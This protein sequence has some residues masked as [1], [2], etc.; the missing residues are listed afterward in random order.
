MHPLA[1]TGASAVTAG[2]LIGFVLGFAIVHSEL[3]WEKTF[4]DFFMLKNGKIGSII[5]FSICV[6]TFLFFLLKLA[7]AVQLHIKPSSFWASFIG[8]A[9]FGAGVF[10]CRQV[11]ITSFALFGTGRTYALWTLAGMLLAIPAVKFCSGFLSDT[12]YAFSPPFNYEKT[13][14]VYMPGAL[15]VGII[16]FIALLLSALF[17]FMFSGASDSGGGDGKK[18]SSSGKSAKKPKGKKGK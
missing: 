13:I 9:I 5:L 18:S 7:G 1:L 16:S 15:A 8:G 17:H 14:D 2:L 12:V 3:V 11:P 10:I 4:S 6:G